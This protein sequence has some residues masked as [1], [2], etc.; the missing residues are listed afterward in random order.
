MKELGRR[1]VMSV[2]IEGGGATHASAFRAGIVDKVLFFVAPKIVGGRE[3]VTAVEGEGVATMD[4]AVELE[5]MTATP[6]GEDILIEAYVR[7][8]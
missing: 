1:E 3:S 5:N 7:K 6:V 8:R 4:L 2:L